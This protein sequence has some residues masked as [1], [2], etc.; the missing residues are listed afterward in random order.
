MSRAVSTLEQGSLLDL[1]GNDPRVDPDYSA[2][3]DACRSV[4]MGQR[5]YV[6]INDVRARLTN[7]WGMTIEPRL[8]SSFW[9][10][11]R[12]DGHLERTSIRERNN[13]RK[14]RNATKEQYLY[15]WIGGPS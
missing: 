2:F 10:R 15:R 9:R 7:D 8:Y 1:I 12:L 6:S 11:A 5:A 4:R 13:D 3:L 14:G